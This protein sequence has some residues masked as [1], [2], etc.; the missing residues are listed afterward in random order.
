MNKSNTSGEK[1]LKNPP[2]Q[3]PPEKKQITKGELGSSWIAFLRL[4]C[5]V[6]WQQMHVFS[7]C[8][9]AHE[10]YAMEFRARSITKC[11]E[12]K[13]AAL[14]QAPLLILCPCERLLFS[15]QSSEPAWRTGCVLTEAPSFPSHRDSFCFSASDSLVPLP[16]RAP[17]LQPPLLAEVKHP[18]QP[19]AQAAS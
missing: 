13:P 2:L 16:L 15:R 1:P 9:S 14:L 3:N 11:Q 19:S 5:L 18:P 7:V 4:P 8:L 10:H 6:E 12:Q 17:V